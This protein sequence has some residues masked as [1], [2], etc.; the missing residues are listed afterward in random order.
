MQLARAFDDAPA[1]WLVSLHDDVPPEADVI[2]CG[3]EIDIE[4]AV[5]FD[6]Q[7]PQ[8]A[9]AEVQKR[10]QARSVG[11][12]IFV[13]GATGGSGAT[14]LALHLAA[15]GRACVVEASGSGVRRRLELASA[16]S[17]PTATDEEP[18]PL[19]VSPGLRVLL[20][21]KSSTIEDARWIVD[22]AASAFSSVI[23]DCESRNV[24]ELVAPGDIGVLVTLP[25]RPAIERAK[26]ILGV[27]GPRW[28]VVT[29]RTGPGGCLTRRR[30]EV[31]LDQRIAIE[32]P[33]SAALRD[34]EDE[35]GLLTSPMSPWWWKV[36]RLWRALE[37]A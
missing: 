36:K 7:T 28:A 27:D 18:A 9:I 20:A 4:G 23:V 19:P 37:T 5:P 13:C 14:T 29:N 31:L 3:R 25:T 10:A 21:P 17:W 35:G 6:P 1:S 22:R 24:E 33:C 2:V 8:L 26:E 30:L 16:R 34:A 11:R 32:L 15:A 12:R